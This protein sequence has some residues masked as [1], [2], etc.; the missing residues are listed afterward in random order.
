MVKIMMFMLKNVFSNVNLS[1]EEMRFSSNLIIFTL[2]CMIILA[3][4]SIPYVATAMI[5]I[6]GLSLLQAFVVIGFAIGVYFVLVNMI[7][8]MLRSVDPFLIILNI[9]ITFPVFILCVLFIPE[10]IQTFTM[11]VVAASFVLI[12]MV[13]WFLWHIS[14][15]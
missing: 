2:Q 9:F 11:V 15:D 12:S 1:R 5:Y 8:L 4:N 6:F 7:F 13:S 14:L 3:V 10:M